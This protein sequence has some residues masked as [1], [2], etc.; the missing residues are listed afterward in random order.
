MKL[1][2]QLEELIYALPMT[3]AERQ[4]VTRQMGFL[5]VKEH[6]QLRVALQRRESL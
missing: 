6:Y 2:E 1:Q 5:S 3:N 4:W